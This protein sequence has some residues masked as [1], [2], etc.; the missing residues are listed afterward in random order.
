MDW[1]MH[2][3]LIGTPTAVVLN[4]LMA[5]LALILF[6]RSPRRRIGLS[7]LGAVTGAVVGALVFWWTVQVR[8]VFGVD[9]SSTTHVWT[10]IGFAGVGLAV[11]NLFASR[12]RR[13][14]LAVL[15]IPLLLL[16]PA[17]GINADFGAYRTVGQLFGGDQVPALSTLGTGEHGEV[18]SGR[19]D[20]ATDWQP[21]ADM[22]KH[23]AIG[24]V[25]IPGTL[26]GFETRPAQVWLPP[27]AL[28]ADPPVLPVL[29]IMSG[30]PGSPG[31]N[32]AMGGLDAVLD[33]YASTHRGL[34]PIAVAVDQLGSPDQNPL[35]I[36]SQAFGNAQT[37]LTQDVP[38]WVR[39]NFRV[40]DDPVMWALQGFSQ[41]A[42][43]T[44]QFVTGFP[45]I[46]GSG[47]TTGTQLG[48][49]LG[50]E[51]ETVEK[52]FAGDRAA[53]DAAQP[54]AIMRAHGPYGDSMLLLGVGNTDDRYGAY[55]DQLEAAAKAAGIQVQRLRADTGHDWYAARDI[56]AAGLPILGERMGL[57]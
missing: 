19:P 10:V 55:S 7:V 35:C 11:S 32:F 36:D 24:E 16:A 40:S 2:L 39:A 42:T 8:D 33:D 27:A 1:L 23:G 12:W 26:S 5:V 41:G 18:V 22:P 6:V 44:T 37:Y 29:L 15:A 28:T 51:A 9:L 17:A 53:Y 21:P 49:L 13:K 50:D 4:A 38:A 43:C 52:G 54:I 46:F 3:P 30:Q 48:P 45:Q 56:F 57:Q 25:T 31:E 20:Y 14:I 34:A 47:I